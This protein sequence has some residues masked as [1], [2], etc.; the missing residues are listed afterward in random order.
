MSVTRNSSAPEEPQWATRAELEVLNRDIPRVDGPD[1]VTGRARYTHDIRVTGMCWA[2]VLVYPYPR[3]EV[4]RVDVSAALE[5]PGVLLARPLKGDGDVPD[6]SRSPETIRYHGSDA[7]VAVVAAETPEAAEDALRAIVVEAEDLYPPMV[8][9]EQA[10]DPDSPQLSSRHPNSW[11]EGGG[12]DEEEF[13]TEL[14]FC[15]AVVEAEYS[16]PIQ[17]HVCLETHGAVVDFSGGDRATVYASTQSVSSS[18]SEAARYLGLEESNVNVI[19][20][21]MGGGFGSKFGLGF[22]AR[23]ACTVAR[24]LS[25]PVHLMLKRPEEFVIAGNRSGSYQRFR[26]GATRDGKIMAVEID[27]DKLGGMGRGALPIGDRPYIYSVAAPFIKTRSVTMA[28]DPNRAMRAPGHPQAS[29]AMESFV[30]ELAYAIEMDPLE[31]RKANLENEI[32]HRQL[33]R[34]AA[35]IGWQD[36]PNKTRPGECAGGINEGI[37][38][39]VA[40]WSSGARGG[41]QCEVRVLPD[42]SVTSTAG[43]QDLGTGS[44]TYVAAIVA[45]EL[46][47]EVGDVSAQ[48]GE[49]RFPP[50]ASSGGSVTTGCSAPAIKDAA[51]QAREGL[52]TRL[53]AALGAEVGGYTWKDGRVFVTE[54]PSRGMAWTQVCALLG[55]EPLVALG[56]WQEHLW[57]P[58]VHGAQAARVRVDTLTGELQ[59]TAMVYIQ[60]CGL[61][62]NRLAARSQVNGGQVQALSYGLFEERIYDPDLGLN[63]SANLEDYK[64]AG[65]QETGGIVS[66]LDDDDDRLAT[67]GMAEANCIPGHGAIANAL[68]NACGVRIRHLPLTA[69]KIINAIHGA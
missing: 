21:H 50:S 33:D 64:I 67:M 34:V 11:A 49:S 32:W 20:H 57:Q 36:H 12:G 41:S 10:L 25:R 3:A 1:K 26:G 9:R 35:E 55:S 19:T 52:E 8:T 45:E 44:R 69:D 24:E 63:L 46:G 7:V 47:L 14:E 23:L 43:T 15:D 60:D 66:I 53:S 4:A 17:H 27:A 28:L 58:G 5:L 6:W 38:F 30:D 22:E 48:I 42:G 68:Y 65:S 29:W 31:F 2:R 59:V 51:H 54:D 37:G 40:V 13:Q 16:A 62:L 39:G 18:G 56:S 61:V